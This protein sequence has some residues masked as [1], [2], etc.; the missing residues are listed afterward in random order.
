[1]RGSGAQAI[2]MKVWNDVLKQS[3]HCWFS[4][5]VFSAAHTCIVNDEK[6]KSRHAVRLTATMLLV[7]ARALLCSK[8]GVQCFC[9]FKCD[10]MQL[11]WSVRW[12]L[13]KNKIS[14]FS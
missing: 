13:S 7:L 10:V 9:C 5:D 12:L 11:L 4:S 1:M 14:F 2:D 3:W 8:I 6:S